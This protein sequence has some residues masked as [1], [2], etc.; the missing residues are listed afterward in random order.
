MAY[1]KASCAQQFAAYVHDVRLCHFE[2]S[3]SHSGDHRALLYL[4]P[5]KA[6]A[7]LSVFTAGPASTALATARTEPASSRLPEWCTV[8]VGAQA[9]TKPGKAF[10]DLHR[11]ASASNR[12]ALS[13]LPLFFLLFNRRGTGGPSG[14][15]RPSSGPRAGP[16]IGVVHGPEGANP[17][18]RPWPFGRSAGSPPKKD[19]PNKGGPCYWCTSY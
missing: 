14:S 9:A 18:G 3:S 10:Q 11:D 8:G 15:S 1:I 19:P 5:C 17:S 4:H 6:A 7:S 2:L 13:T 12:H 16:W